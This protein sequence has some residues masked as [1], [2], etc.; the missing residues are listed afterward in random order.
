M[1]TREN[2]HTSSRERE[3]GGWVFLSSLFGF[4]NSFSFS[5]LLSGVPK[6]RST[7]GLEGV[8]VVGGRGGQAHPGVVWVAPR[9]SLVV[10]ENVVPQLQPSLLAL[11]AG[12]RTDFAPHVPVAVLCAPATL[13]I[14]A[15]AVAVFV[16]LLCVSHL[17][18]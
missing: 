18:G 1:S 4:K 8:V 7:V 10:V 15:W 17:D 12:K 16:L 5:A 13:V 14:V 2:T 6:S 3:G 11:H 9:V